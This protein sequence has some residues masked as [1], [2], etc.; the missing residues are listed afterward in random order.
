MLDKAPPSFTVSPIRCLKARRVSNIMFTRMGT[1]MA[2]PL[3]DGRLAG[4]LEH[5]SLDLAVGG[6][7]DGPSAVR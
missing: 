3:H 4:V 1:T 6:A 2:T 5:A 7:A